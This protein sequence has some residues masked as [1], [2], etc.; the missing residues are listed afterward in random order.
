MNASPAFRRSLCLLLCLVLNG[1]PSRGNETLRVSADS[2]MPYNG[3][4]SAAK[5]GY[6][7]ELLK[8]IFEP[9]GT[10]VSYSLMDYTEALKATAEGSI[11]AVIG[12][13]AVEGAGLIL[14]K[15]PMSK[16]CV[17]LLSLA[18]SEFSYGNLRSLRGNPLGA[19]EGYSYWDSLNSYIE[20]GKDVVLVS[21]EDPLKDLVAKLDAKE[22]TVLAET[23]PVL[24]WHLR[25]ADRPKTDFKAVYR[26]LADPIYVA[27]APNEKGK[28]L[29]ERF[30]K[31]ILE[32]RK[33]GQLAKLLAAYGLRDWVD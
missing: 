4:P 3:D 29:A 15:Q 12:P 32:L 6:V 18:S 24:L 21:G 25:E 28:A 23:E 19:I 2:W 22:I 13:D 1:L 31:G 33:S 7:I 26:H 27:F 10:S 30:D 17:I 14:P 9:E 5:P 11:D 20:K 16:P 8:T